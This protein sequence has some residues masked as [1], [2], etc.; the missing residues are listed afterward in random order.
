[1]Q[2]SAHSADVLSVEVIGDEDDV[3]LVQHA[4]GQGQQLPEG[5]GHGALPALPPEGFL[6]HVRIR[7][8]AVQQLGKDNE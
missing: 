4:E 5:G 1:M 3:K 2:C 6:Q 8:L 7:L